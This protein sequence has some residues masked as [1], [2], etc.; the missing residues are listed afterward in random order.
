M[1]PGPLRSLISAHPVSRRGSLSRATATV[2]R[3]AAMLKPSLAWLR[4]LCSTALMADGGGRR[5]PAIQARQVDFGRL[6]NAASPAAW[7]PGHK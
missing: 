6:V 7:R 4:N 3:N 1:E 5:Y 2:S